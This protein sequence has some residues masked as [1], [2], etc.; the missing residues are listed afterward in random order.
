M[1]LTKKHN[2]HI[3]TNKSMH[4]EMGPARRNPISKYKVKK[5]F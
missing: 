3:N 4:S 2:A 5:I 1:Q